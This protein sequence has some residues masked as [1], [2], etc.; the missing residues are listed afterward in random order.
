MSSGKNGI[1]EFL[2]AR[3]AE[4]D[5]SARTVNKITLSLL[6]NVQI[7]KLVERG[8]P[9]TILERLRMQK[10]S[11]I[12]K[13]NTMYFPIDNLPFL[14]VIPG[15]VLPI[16]EQARMIVLPGK[17]GNA[18]CQCLLKPSEFRSF[19]KVEG[20]YFISD[21]ENGARLRDSHPCDSRKALAGSERRGLGIEEMISLAI[22][23]DAL[24]C[25]N[26]L[27]IAINHQNAPPSKSP[28]L[29][30]K[31]GVPHLC[32]IYN[33]RFLGKPPYRHWGTPYWGTPSCASLII[34]TG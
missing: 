34:K 28:A 3:A 2:A 23:S 8:C 31:Q 19:K 16:E 22:H 26:L 5:D 14:P 21:V 10:P 1:N 11:V 20:P 6:F 13:A 17:N 29:A 4:Q 27:A 18:E 9:P 24:S 32:G 12:A 33:Y 25:H 7:Q 30:L 15:D